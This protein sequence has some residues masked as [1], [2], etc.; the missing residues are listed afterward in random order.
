M[1][2]SVPHILQNNL[3]VLTILVSGLRSLNIFIVVHH[4]EHVPAHHALIRKMCP[5]WTVL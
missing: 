2:L 5:F 4:C 3:L 1:L